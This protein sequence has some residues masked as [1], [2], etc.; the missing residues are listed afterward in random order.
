LSYSLTDDLHDKGLR[1]G[2][3]AAVGKFVD[4]D[5]YLPDISAYT[6]DPQNDRA[7]KLRAAVEKGDVTLTLS[8]I[9]YDGR[10]ERIDLNGAE[11]RKY[12]E[13]SLRARTELAMGK[14]RE[15]RFAVASD[16]AEKIRAV[17]GLVEAAKVTPY[18]E[19]CLREFGGIVEK[20]KRIPLR[21][22]GYRMPVVEVLREDWGEN[23]GGSDAQIQR[24]YLDQEWL[25]W[26][27]PLG[28][29][30]YLNDIWDQAAKCFW[31]WHHDP[32]AQEGCNIIRNF[33]IGRGVTVEAKDKNVQRVIDTFD[34]FNGMAA[35]WKTW[36]VGLSRDGELFVRK[37][38]MAD[39]TGRLRVRGLSPDTIWEVV[40][41]AEDIETV[42]Y[43][44]QRYMTRT[45]LFEPPSGDAQHWV[46]RDLPASEVIH[47][48][49]NVAESEVRGRSDLFVILGHLKRL[50]DLSDTVVLKDQAQAAYQYDFTVD[51]G[52][53]E[54]SNFA[55]TAL[56]KGKPQPGSYFIHNKAATVQV[57]D[58]GKS[59]TSGQGSSWEMLVTMCA[60]G[61]GIAKDY[62][63]V[64]SRGSRATALVATEPTAMRL[65]ERQDTLT[66]VGT[67]VYRAALVEAKKNGG[68]Q[69]KDGNWI[70][71][72]G[73]KD[74]SFKI[75]FPSIEKSDAGDRIDH[76]NQGV[77][78]QYLSHRTG[79][80]MYAN[81]MDIDEYD[82][83][84]ECALIAA[85]MERKNPPLILAT[86]SNLPMGD[87]T[88]G[89]AGAPFGSTPTSPAP[90][91][92]G[93]PPANGKRGAPAHPAKPGGDAS[94]GAGTKSPLSSGGAADIRNDLGR[95]GKESRALEAGQ[96]VTETW[97]GAYA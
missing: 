86:Y 63:G 24:G 56:P 27:G 93:A 46:S 9:A 59:Q 14:I 21:E 65:E 84:A 77:G 11:T 62:L 4:A 71:V 51:G 40:T 83:D 42:Y 31:A 66:D 58:S 80:T 74:W 78:M 29:Q 72:S 6:P 2:D 12:F 20:R 85:E 38:P 54:I 8:T 97:A 90:G 79:A 19:A 39:G 52:P 81:E 26:S 69:D 35:R 22:G 89:V 33:V 55:S 41:D 17:G 23:Y 18:E 53:T 49:V 76:V 5:P 48:K 13:S 30:L 57:L 64:T 10:R 92:P 91:T 70:D 16:A 44:A 15:K 87:A 67:D 73:V 45:Q 7:Q 28:Q 94:Q 3:V 32:I 25:N 88:S 50:R 60:I 75:S 36:T 37:I 43:Y 47:A 34:W 61:L 82:Y 1:P 95:H 96:S 68:C